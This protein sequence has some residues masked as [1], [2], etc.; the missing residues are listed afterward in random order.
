MRIKLLLAILSISIVS[1]KN[2]HVKNKPL[3]VGNPRIIDSL[4][5]NKYYDNARWL[6]YCKYCDEKV[7]CLNDSITLGEATIVGNEVHLVSKDTLELGFDFI[8]KDSASCIGHYDKEQAIIGVAYNIEND[9]LIY[10]L[11]AGV[12]KRFKVWCDTIPCNNRLVLPLQPEVIAY[13]KKNRDKLDPWF[14]DEAIKRGVI[15]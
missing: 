11:G 5:L 2:G 15:K 3:N 10:F 7:V 1:C 6:M 13:I 14:R 9:S 12:T 8:S 4:G